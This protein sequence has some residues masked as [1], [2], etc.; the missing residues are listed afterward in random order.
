MSRFPR[1]GLLLCFAP[2]AGATTPAVMARLPLRFEANWGQAPAH[3]RYT[4]HAGS[5]TMQFTSA[6][7]SMLD[8]KH[9]VDLSLVGGN[10]APKVEALAPTDARTD[11]FV[12]RRDEWRTNIPSFGRV[13][14][15][16]VYPGI[17]MVYYGNQS[18]LEYDFVVAPGADPRVIRMRFQ[19]AK[20]VRI[21]E[22]G[23]LLVD[24]M[25]QKRP[26]IY[27]DSPR[28]EITGRY[29]MLGKNTVGVRVGPYDRSRELVI[30]PVLSYATYMGGT[31]GDRINAM[32]L[33]G[34]KLYV[35]GQTTNQDLGST[36][37]AYSTTF[38]AITDIFVAI[39]DATP[40]AGYP[41]LYMTYFGGNA[42]DIP[43]AIDVD[44][45]GFVYLTGSTTSTNF[46]LAGGSFQNTGATTN[47][48]SFVVKLHPV[49]PGT[50]ALWYSSYLGGD[51]GEVIGNG[52]AAGPDGSV[53][54]V[55]TTKADNFPTTDNAYQKVRWGNQDAFITK[56]APDGTVAYSSYLGGEGLDDGR[57]VLLGANGLVYLAAST[58]SDYFPMAGFSAQPSRAGAQDVVVDVLDLNKSG[59]A[60]LV[61]G[62]FYG[63]SGNEEV[64]GMTFDAQGDVVITGYTLSTDLPTTFDAMYSQ[65]GGNGDAFV[66]VLNPS[67]AFAQGL[68]YSTYFGGSHGDVA[69]QVAASKDGSIAVAGYTLSADLPVTADAPQPAWGRGTDLFV[70]KFKPGVAGKGALDYSTFLG[71]TATYLPTGMT[72]GEDGSLYVVGYG[73]GGM[74]VTDN[75]RQSVFFGGSAD[76]FIVVL[77]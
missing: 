60:S 23:D 70:A 31:G 58:L 64:R 61:Y 7:A 68:K 71:A 26:V 75:A 53:Y 5:Y 13:K 74:P 44:A 20:S 10:R 51:A 30:D 45:S 19:G 18:Q 50:D 17:E 42:V 69:Y 14:Y 76:G 9:R 52:I 24:D 1:F 73:G 43:T 49:D 55:G 47:A 39:L 54:I 34:N 32:K 12:G 72:F 15:G 29:V 59:E 48:C 4:A 40:G 37:D 2:L 25:I 6:G 57:A 63:G 27:Q 11:Y 3:V 22:A 77:K 16:A 8:G 38:I 65:S 21:S 67:V 36:P 66:A 35:T 46:P 41:L 28:R 56:F 33:V 62:T